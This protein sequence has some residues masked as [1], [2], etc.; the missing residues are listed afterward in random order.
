MYFR[1]LETFFPM[2]LIEL[3]IKLL[4]N[5]NHFLWCSKWNA[6]RKVHFVQDVLTY[7]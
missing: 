7:F 5:F 3:G 6:F 1:K 2:S 4:M